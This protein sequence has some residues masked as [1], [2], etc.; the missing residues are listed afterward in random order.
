M[1][2]TD[3][4]PQTVDVVTRNTEKAAKHL[5]AVNHTLRQQMLKKIIEK[6]QMTV[7]EL[8]IALRLDQSVCSQHLKIL[9]DAK[10]VS[11]I[12]EGKYIFYAVRLDR[13]SQLHE[14]SERMNQAA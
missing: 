11:T 1:K 9:R 12:R 4:T 8:Y 6:G 3:F 7:S 13:L 5:R 14:L 2:H 10:V